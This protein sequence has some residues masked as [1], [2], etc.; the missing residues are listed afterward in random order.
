MSRPHS[1]D[2]NE[3]IQDSGPL[4]PP[5]PRP[6]P[7]PPPLPV[8]AQVTLHEADNG[9]RS[10]S[11]NTYQAAGLTLT[12]HLP[13][14]AWIVAGGSAALMVSLAIVLVVIANLRQAA[15]HV[16]NAPRR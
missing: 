12:S 6:A 16:G 10:I 9:Q 2:D 11:R 4:P 15:A 13:L 7:V 8:R 14:W 5:L 3:A 1:Q